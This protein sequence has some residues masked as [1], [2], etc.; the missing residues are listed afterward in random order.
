MK[1]RGFFG[2]L[3]ASLVAPI[4]SKTEQ[5]VQVDEWFVGDSPVPQRVR[6]RDA[7]VDD[8]VFY[9][10]VDLILPRESRSMAWFKER[11]P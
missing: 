5:W 6:V 4:A 11:Y 10:S 8:E 7:Y 9:G 1:R 2:L 3:L